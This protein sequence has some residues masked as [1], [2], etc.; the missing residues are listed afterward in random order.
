MTCPSRLLVFVH[1]DGCGGP[2]LGTDGAFLE[3]VSQ[4]GWDISD[5][6]MPCGPETGLHIFEGW[7]EIGPEPNP[8]TSFVGE[9]RRLTFWEMCRVRFGLAPW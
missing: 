1:P 9:W 8:D 5:H 7:V 6:D 2:I 4:A 3:E